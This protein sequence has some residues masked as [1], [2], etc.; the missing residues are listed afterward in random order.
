MARLVLSLLGTFTATL[1]GRPLTDFGYDKVR[2]LLAFLAVEARHSHRRERLCGLFWPESAPTLARQNLS[3]ALYHLRRVLGE[4]DIAFLLTDRQQ[5]RFN[6]DSDHRLDVA[7]FHTLVDVGNTTPTMAGLDGWEQ[8]V[9]LYKGPF[10]EGFSLP[11]AA[12]FEEWSL[13][14]REW[15]QRTALETLRHL[16]AGWRDRADPERALGHA[17][18][19]IEL[20]PWEE[21]AH[22]QI[23]QLLV[24]C[25]RPGE[26]LAQYERCRCILRRELDVEPRPETVE[27]YIDI[28]RNQTKVAEDT[29]FLPEIRSASLPPQATPLIGRERELAQIARRLADPVCRLLTIVGPGGI[30]KT[31]LAIQAAQ[32]QIGRFAHGVYFIDLAPISGADLLPIAILNALHAPRHG[33]LNSTQQLLAFLRNREMLL[34]LDNCEHL[35]AGV[36]LLTPM[37]HAAPALKLL[38]TSRE[39]LKL[40]AEWQLPLDGLDVPP[41]VNLVEDAHTYAGA[42]TCEPNPD[43]ALDLESYGAIRLFLHCIRRLRPGFRSTP[44]E[45]AHIVHIC[46]MLEGLPLAIEL[47]A[48][49]TRTLPCA[50]IAQEMT[51]S[52]AL[53]TTP[54]R[55]VPDRH[56]SMHAT[57]DHSWRLLSGREQSRLRQLAV[58]R[59]GFTREAAA[60]VAGAS[61][62]DL[63]GLV[64]ASWLRVTPAGRYSMHELIRQYCMEKLE[65]EHLPVDGESSDWVRDRHCTYFET[66]LQAQEQGYNWQHQAMAT[67]TPEFGNITAAWNWAV[68]SG[69]VERIDS[70]TISLFFIGDME[71]WYQTI[72]DVFGSATRK[73]RAAF[74]IDPGQ[75][76]H[77]QVAAQLFASLGY[78]Q[79]HLYTSLGLLD[80][81]MMCVDEAEAT[82]QTTAWS[83]RVEE[84]QTWL[85]HLRAL[86]LNLQGRSA[87]AQRLFHE[88][89]L[90]LQKTDIAFWPHVPEVGTRFMQAHIYANLGQAAWARGDYEAAERNVRQAL[91]MREQTGERRFRAEN[92]RLLARILQTTGDIVQAETLAQESLRLS[93]AFGDRIG[94]AKAC[95]ALGRLHRASG[96][97]AN[98]RGYC[99]QSLDVA[100]HTGHHRLWMGSLIELGH[101]ALALGDTTEAKQLFEEAISVFSA[102][103]TT[104]SPDVVAALL[105]LGRTAL[106]MGD[107]PL[108]KHKFQQVLAAAGRA[109]CE[110]MEAIAG[111]ARGLCDEGQSQRA[112]ALLA[113][114][115]ESPATAHA[116]RLLARG[117]LSEL[118]TALSPNLFTQAIGLGSQRRV[119][120]VI[121]ELTR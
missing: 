48:A 36:G 39:R 76:A 57:F 34:V 74:Q 79:G 11:D 62:A 100:R 14:Q 116:T 73:L 108:A 109:A 44:D 87:D 24:Q 97:Y 86:V 98:G 71:G 120:E 29:R 119:E 66:F 61:L 85:R 78:C 96:R 81:A 21:D 43:P 26:A 94:V 47:A 13:L 112:A 1:D 59:G 56:R 38:V 16:V 6:P 27:L 54:L 19:L 117:W 51:G 105:G 31:R 49:W 55:D 84:W 42:A 72:L 3:Q 40:H 113:L 114:V 80:Q 50:Q 4:T 77:S 58:F 63:A 110:T 7:E 60:S 35:L 92:L 93:Q 121:L 82:L 115:E 99:Q 83:E 17:W 89:L 118:E 53:L 32:E 75:V 107:T 45:V 22:R 95:L 30:G 8:A 25:E 103:Q 64:D 28:Q 10:L 52:L 68:D 9:A 65:R 15:L 37:L 69:Q 104:H 46:Q 23:M 2:A 18:R 12:P 106:A 90:Y 91:V 41:G 70:M 88:L 5:V 20:E 33:I 102:L 101:I 111:L 67:I